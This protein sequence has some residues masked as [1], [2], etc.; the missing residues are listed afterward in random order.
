MPQDGNEL[1][2]HLAL[3]VPRARRAAKPRRRWRGAGRRHSTSCPQGPRRGGRRWRRPRRRPGRRHALPS[4]PGGAVRKRRGKWCE[5]PAASCPMLPASTAASCD[6]PCPAQCSWGAAWKRQE[7][8]NARFLQLP[9]RRVPLQLSCPMLPAPSC[10]MLPAIA[11]S[12]VTTP[13]RAG[14]PAAALR[15]RRHGRH[16]SPHG[17]RRSRRWHGRRRSRRH[18]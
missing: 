10:L 12:V 7:G 5:L 8:N 15:R 11:R 17:R 4:A 18:G 14:A 9:A 3:V 2:A 13:C 1:P 6:A 16:R